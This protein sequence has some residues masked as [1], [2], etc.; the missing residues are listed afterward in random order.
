[1][2][3]THVINADLVK[4]W[5][6]G[7]DGKSV[8]RTTVAWGDQVEVKEQTPDRILL[9]VT[10]YQTQDDG[11]VLPFDRE[12]FIAKPTQSSGLSIDELVMPIEESRVMKIEFVDVQQG[13]AT[14]MESPQGKV[15]LIDG[16]ETVLFARYLATRY[17]GSFADNPKE[18]D[19]ILVSHGDADHFA[20]LTEIHESETS[21]YAYKRLFI[22][23][24]RVY[25]NGLVKRPSTT[26]GRDTRDVELLGETAEKDG[27][28]YIIDLVEEL[29]EVEDARMNEPFK[30]WKEAL[31]AFSDRGDIEFRRL[32]KGTE[33]AFDFL[34]DENID[35]K[36]VAPIVEEVDG[37]PALRFLGTPKP[38]VEY[39]E[40]P[41]GPAYTGK[42]ASHTINGHS[43][44][45]Q[46]KYGD[47][48][49]LLAGDLNR[50]SE[51]FLLAAHEAGEMDLE[52]DVLK[53]PHHGS[54]DFSDEF[55]R[56]TSPIVSVISSGD[57]NAAKEY[58][59]PR[60]TLMGALG[61]NSRPN[62]TQPLIF[63][64]EMVAFFQTEGFVHPEFHVLD[65][66][67]VVLDETGLAKKDAKARSTF[68]AF[69]RAAFGTVKLRTDG[70][71]LLVWTN[72]GQ[73]DLKEAYAYE[74][75]DGTLARVRLR[76]P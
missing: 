69:S 27:T 3:P 61:K 49:F 13:D 14:V 1:M 16:G 58:I 40:Q 32:D 26:D 72:S 42:S 19:C 67:E 28:T 24:Q 66:G 17:R 55:L 6:T 52:T 18:I 56:A 33:D 62:G 35:V 57:E 48:R 30:K 15:L 21:D 9:N 54:A 34:A 12:G 25:H 76:R 60:A 39:G 29:L 11:S 20:G 44:V 5:T 37:K 70:K 43:V 7:A 46:M 47:V 71:R 31:T 41:T 65:D 73:R 63:V 53:V 23:P 10:D 8:Y 50:Q 4:I 64:T 51:E 38:E 36:V 22:H 45:L 59:H 2:N 68:F 74:S 75:R